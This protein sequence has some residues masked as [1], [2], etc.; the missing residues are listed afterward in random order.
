MADCRET[1]AELEK[2]LDQE[3]GSERTEEI[4]GHLKGC[5]D[6]QGAYEFHHELRTTIRSQAQN[7]EL[8]EGFLEKLM[9]CFGDEVLGD[10]LAD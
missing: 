1:L 6:C 9:E 7:D 10:S 5:T 4:L 8:P 3:L 2:F